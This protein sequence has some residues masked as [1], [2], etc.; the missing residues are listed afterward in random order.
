LVSIL[1]GVVGVIVGAAVAIT[2]VSMNIPQGGGGG[3]SQG[4]S[5]GG[6][7]NLNISGLPPE[8]AQLASSLNASE[9]QRGINLFNKQLTCWT[10]HMVRS[11]GLGQ[12]N[13]GPDL[14]A[15]LLGNPGVPPS[16]NPIVR[17]YSENGLADPRTN[18]QKAVELLTEFLINPPGYAS[19]M[20]S[21]IA[22]FRQQYGNQ[23]WT[24]YAHAIAQML[25]YA[26]LKAYQ[27]GMVSG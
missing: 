2:Y 1:V 19:Q 12:G 17:W 22:G 24:Q 4:S 6:G 5:Q 9:I 7:I 11:L 8:L 18:P 26:S 25:A 15:V 10:C 21:V 13:V 14:S 23:T 3:G 16:Q 20:V 27:Q